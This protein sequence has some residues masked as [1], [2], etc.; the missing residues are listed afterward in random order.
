MMKNKMAAVILL[1]VGV[2]WLGGCSNLQSLERTTEELDGVGQRNQG[3]EIANLKEERKELVAEIAELQKVVGGGTEKGRIQLTAMEPETLQ[4][5]RL[6]QALQQLRGNLQNQVQQFTVLQSERDELVH[7][8]QDL[9]AKLQG[10]VQQS[11]SQEEILKAQKQER[12]RLT[13]EVQQL[14]ADVD[15]E[16]AQ[17]AKMFK[18]ELGDGL[19]VEQK[20]NRLILTVLDQVLFESGEIELTPLGLEVMKRVGKVLAGLSDKSIQIEGHTD[21]NPIHGTLKRR[22]PTNWELSTARATTVLRF[23][24][25]KTKMNSSR[26]VAA[27]YADTRPVASNDTEKGRSRNR[28]VE[29]VLFPEDAFYPKKEAMKEGEVLHATK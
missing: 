27:G 25:E 21:A 20:N 10:I 3:S 16:M 5:G 24:I 9:E 1:V 13:Q 2:T 17:V 18:K 22:Y 12:D 8:I 4:Y 29:I 23:L 26:F 11:V 15:A 19:R 28:R 7:D 14:Q 6:S